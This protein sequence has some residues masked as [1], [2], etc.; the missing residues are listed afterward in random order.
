MPRN[1]Y[2]RLFHIHAAPSHSSYIR[3]P[4]T[5]LYGVLLHLQTYSMFSTI[6]ALLLVVISFSKAFAEFPAGEEVARGTRMELILTGILTLNS[7]TKLV[8]EYI[9]NE[10]KQEPIV[11]PPPTKKKSSYN[12][13]GRLQQRCQRLIEMERLR[14]LIEEHHVRRF[15]QE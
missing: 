2:F 12:N 7:I 8:F 14:K 11:T 15:P 13:K 4:F 1:G 3:S 6:L 9:E 10:R 5:A